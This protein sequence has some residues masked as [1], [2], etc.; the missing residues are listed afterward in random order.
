MINILVCT[1]LFFF[2]GKCTAFLLYH[3]SIGKILATRLFQRYTI[4]EIVKKT[5]RLQAKVQIDKIAENVFQFIFENKKDQDFV[6][7]SRPW[8]LNG[9]LLILKEWSLNRAITIIHFDS[10]TFHVQIHGLPP[11][12]LHEETAKS[13]GSNKSVCCT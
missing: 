13:I 8:S 3:Y 4:S 7:R 1:S 5:W 12:F 9:F 6:F 10:A 2:F 11:M